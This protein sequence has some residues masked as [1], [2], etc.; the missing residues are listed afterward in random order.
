MALEALHRRVAVGS[1]DSLLLKLVLEND[2]TPTPKP[3]VVFLSGADCPHE[4]YMWLAARLARAGCAVAL[5]SCV[6]AFG[7]STCLLSAP[8]DLTALGSL[9]AYRRNPSSAGLAAI[10]DALRAL[11][12]P[13]GELEGRLDVERL[14]VGGHSSGGRTALDLGAFDNPLG[15]RAVFSY[16]ASLV[17]S[18]GAFAPAAACSRATR[19]AARCCCWRRRRRRLGRTLP[20]GEATET[21]RRTLS[22]GVASESAPPSCACFAARI[23]WSSASR[24][25]RRAAHSKPT[26]LSRRAPTATRSAR[27]SA[28]SSSTFSPHTTLLTRRHRET[29]NARRRWSPYALRISPLLFRAAAAKATRTPPLQRPPRRRNGHAEGSDARRGRRCVVRSTAGSS[30]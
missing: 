27:A 10:V 22:E 23:I 9:D 15:A 13:G 2:P 26:G 4:S 16:G 8:F 29:R 19:G 18:G 20:A 24:S 7:P 3:C 28:R 30:D 5:S 1:E 6:V 12:A 17:N 21:L 14:A 25:I 11:S